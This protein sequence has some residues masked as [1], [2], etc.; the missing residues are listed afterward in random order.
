[1]NPVP[2]ATTIFINMSPG[3]AIDRPTRTTGKSTASYLRVGFLLARRLTTAVTVWKSPATP[4]EVRNPIA[5][6]K[7]K[8]ISIAVLPLEIFRS[9][10]PVY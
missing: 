4:T 10:L 7:T 3:R 8:L 1:M 5:T 2:P 6:K 9:H